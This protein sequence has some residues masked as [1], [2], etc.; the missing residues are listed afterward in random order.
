M[1]RILLI[2]GV[3]WVGLLLLTAG[4]SK[5][6]ETQ[7]RRLH[8]ASLHEAA[9]QLEQAEKGYLD[10]LGADAENLEALTRL[11]LL[12]HGWSRFDLAAPLLQR[13]RDLRPD[14]LEVRLK[15][16]AMKVATRKMEEAREDLLFVLGQTPGQEEAL[17]LLA[18]TVQGTNGEALVRQTLATN[19]ARV[20]DRSVLHLGLA[21]LASLQ[22]NSLRAAEELQQAWKLDPRSSAV[23]LAMA[24]L[25]AASNDHTKAEA[26]FE[27]ARAL[28]PPGAPPLLHLVDYKLSRGANLEARNLLEEITSYSPNLLSAWQRAADLAFQE[29]RFTNCET[30]VNHLLSICPTDCQGLLL[31]EQLRLLQGEIEGPL[32]EVTR[33]C[34]RYPRAASARY[35]LGE[36]YLLKRDQPGAMGHLAKALELDPGHKE[37][38]LRFAELKLRLGQY[39]Q[40]AE[41]LRALN[42]RQPGVLQAHLLLADTYRLQGSLQEALA[43]YEQIAKAIPSNATTFHMIGLT[44][45]MGGETNEALQAF[46]TALRLAPASVATL[47]EL[48]ELEREA[49]HPEA[50][51][52]RIQTALAQ[53]P[54]SAGHWALLAD[55]QY[56]LKHPSEAEAALQKA[57]KLDPSSVAANLFQVRLQMLQTNHLGALASTETVLAREPENL[58]ALLKKAWLLKALTNSQQSLATYTKLLQVSPRYVPGLL[59]LVALYLEDLN[60]PKSALATAK[61]AREMDP[62]EPKTAYY[63]GAVLLE[64]KDYAEAVIRLQEGT[65]GLLP[66]DDA[67]YRLGLA[68]YMTGNEPSARTAL[69]RALRSGLKPSQKSEVEACLGFLNMN[70]TRASNTNIAELERRLSSVPEDPVALQRLELAYEHTGQDLQLPDFYE[71][72]AQARPYDPLP[73]VKLARYYSEKI[74]DPARALTNAIAAHKLDRD[75]PAVLFDLARVAAKNR[76]DRWAYSLI[77]ESVRRQTTN[78]EAW[79]EFAQGA[80]RMG[81]LAEA[82]GALRRALETNAPFS[83][84]Q[85]ARQFQEMLELVAAPSRA[86]QKAARVEAVLQDNPDLLPAVFAKGF[87]QEHSREKR[88]AIRTY[89][90]ILAPTHHPYFVPAMRQLAGLLAER[91]VQETRALQLAKEARAA[92]SQDWAA[93]KTLGKLRYRRGE[94]AWAVR[95]FEE[96]GLSAGD[97]REARFYLARARFKANLIKGVEPRDPATLLEAKDL[98]RQA[99]ANENFTF[100]ADLLKVWSSTAQSDAEFWYRLGLA[101]VRLGEVAEAREPLARGLWLDPNHPLAAQAKEALGQSK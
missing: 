48:A 68:F 78:Q 18:E 100:A 96:S 66:E 46:E 28:L 16:A 59:G 55:T 83:R 17:L 71:Q 97:D 31:R 23:H 50:A 90:E 33:L 20:G 91:G 5:Q 56:R 82:E 88:A 84:I 53:Y 2:L 73:L 51:L 43:L 92:D 85:E 63:L 32:E 79:Y 9:G 38:A 81:R 13:V 27:Q 24:S 22:T 26:Q 1:R 39:G 40:A 95:L 37:A 101:Q 34:E 7:A 57:L 41:T 4:C 64:R 44:R 93:T 8:L 54:Q 77:R 94:F 21:S 61:R 70:G 15:L 36:I 14:D 19:R 52:R 3:S 67:W 25:A 49:N 86:L 35:V 60:D 99:W 45:R 98:S 29:R 58:T 30:A 65:T 10:V 72:A 42:R 89:E 76:D 75:D 80:C 69:T 6:A 62:K 47:Q 74:L 11:A 12:Y 87:I